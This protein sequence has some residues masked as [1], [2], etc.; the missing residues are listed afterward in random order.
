MTEPVSRRIRMASAAL[1]PLTEFLRNSA[2]STCIGHDD[3]CD[4]VFGNPQEPT[5]PGFVDALKRWIDP[6]DK[7]WYAYKPNEATACEASARHLRES[8]GLPFEAA[9]IA[10]TGGA[11]AAMAVAFPLVLDPGDEVVFSV[12]AWFCYEAMLVQAG[13]VPVKV[14]LRPDDFDLDLDAIAAAI[15]ARTR[16]V[17]VNSPH[18]PTGRIYSPDTLRGLAELL[19]RASAQHGRTIYLLSDE[20]YRKLVFDQRE[21]HSPACFYDATLISYSYGKVL[22]TPGARLGYLAFSPNLPG[23]QLLRDTVETAQLGGGW[24]HPNALMQY[25]IDDLEPLSIDLAGLTRKRDRLVA[26]LGDIGYRVHI[27]EGTFYLLCQSPIADDAA[28]TRL[29]AQ[30][31]VY[32]LPGHT[33]ELP[34]YVRICLTANED[35]VERS[36][37]GFRRGFDDA[38]RYEHGDR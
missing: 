30:H 7:N 2:Y 36:I 33:F 3:I 15:T 19:E 24:L 31:N 27:P 10:M 20:P 32:V 21:F 29:L 23:R 22:L 5:L 28:F 16:M 12:P 1:A 18:N 11:F 35:M 37:E 17:I 13:A 14:R 25:A 26:A 8:H 34:G 6:R 4:F 38:Q 9:D